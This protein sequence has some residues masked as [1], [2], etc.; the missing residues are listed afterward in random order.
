MICFSRYYLF[1]RLRLLLQKQLHITVTVAKIFLRRKNKLQNSGKK[2]ENMFSHSL[3]GS[4]V[5]FA[6]VLFQHLFSSEADN[7]GELALLLMNSNY[8]WRATRIACILTSFLTLG[9][10]KVNLMVTQRCYQCPP[11]SVHRHQTCMLKIEV[12]ENGKSSKIFVS[13]NSYMHCMW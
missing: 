1:L 11:C 5:C 9:D 4:K 13:Y 6:V 8:L 2:L 12:N 10:E 7:S 3:N